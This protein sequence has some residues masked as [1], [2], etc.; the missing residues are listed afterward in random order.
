MSDKPIFK[1]NQRE[2]RAEL[3]ARAGG[4]VC[5]TSGP[6]NA[7]T[8]YIYFGNRFVLSYGPYAGTDRDVLAKALTVVRE[9]GAQ[10][11]ESL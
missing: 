5:A 9:A 2:L 7:K 6:T 11:R 3:A 8:I 1:M 4:N 10:S